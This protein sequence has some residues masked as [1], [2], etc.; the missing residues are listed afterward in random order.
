M[1]W[2][3][4]GLRQVPREIA[5]AIQAVLAPPCSGTTHWNSWGRPSRHGSDMDKRPH[6]SFLRAAHLDLTVY[7]NLE[8]DTRTAGALRPHFRSACYKSDAFCGCRSNLLTLHNS[9]PPL[10]YSTFLWYYLPVIISCLRACCG[11]KLS[12]VFKPSAR[13]L[14]RKLTTFAWWE[15]RLHWKGF[16][17]PPTF[18]PAARVCC[19]LGNEGRGRI[20]M[21]PPRPRHSKEQ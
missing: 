9:L 7:E 18:I 2:P 13:I 20:S 3:E 16:S 4:V 1:S 10:I 17:P 14:C 21:A 12:P 19:T 5:A 8:Q 11:C 15:L 6:S